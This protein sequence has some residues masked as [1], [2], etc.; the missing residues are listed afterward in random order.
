MIKKISFN[1]FQLG[2]VL[3]TAFVASVGTV[4]FLNQNEA[5]RNSK[6]VDACQPI[7]AAFEDVQAL[8]DQKRS[9]LELLLGQQEAG[10][11]D[12]QVVDYEFKAWR[13][14]DAELD[15]RGDSLVGEITVLECTPLIEN[16]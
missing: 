2:L 8:R 6:R 3:T 9:R 1:S 16:P 14:Q 7:I 10:L 15:R 5:E 12:S 4:A 13:V 11:V